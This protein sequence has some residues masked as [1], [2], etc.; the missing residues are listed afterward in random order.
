M[1]HPA[2]NL[3]FHMLKVNAG[4][5]HQFGWSPMLAWF[6]REV[7]GLSTAHIVIFGTRRLIPKASNSSNSRTSVITLLHTLQSES[8]FIAHIMQNWKT[9]SEKY[10][11]SSKKIDANYGRNKRNYAF[12]EGLVLLDKS[13]QVLDS[14]TATNFRLF[15]N[16][17]KL[18]I[19]S[20]P[21]VKIWIEFCI[22]WSGEG[23]RTC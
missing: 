16:I 22:I 7:F 18:W 12:Q 10:Q 15:V 3:I 11:L 5:L 6:I 4:I 1:C 9:F 8:K 17:G 2:Q 13:G 21:F 19:Q 14:S 23:Q 20:P